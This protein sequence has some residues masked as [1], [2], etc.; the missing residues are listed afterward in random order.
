MSTVIS[1][2]AVAVPGIILIIS[3]CRFEGSAILFPQKG[4]PTAV[5]V[6]VL[7]DLVF[8]LL[9]NNGKYYFYSPDSKVRHCVVR[10]FTLGS[11]EGFIYYYLC[12]DIFLVLYY[13]CN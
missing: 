1:V 3:F 13:L 10:A 12:N 11:C 9:D 2:L 5:Q 7:S 4:K 6:V 8:F